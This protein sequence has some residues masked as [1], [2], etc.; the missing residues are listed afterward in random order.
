[1]TEYDLNQVDKPPSFLQRVNPV[2]PSNA[3]TQGMRAK[4][5]INCLVDEEGI[6]QNIIAA[7]CDPEDALDVFGPPSV[8]AVKK[9]RFNP[10]EIGGESVPTRIAFNIIFELDSPS[11]DVTP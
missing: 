9:W 5:K 8:E 10:G 6:A 4:V 2:Y 11:D 1:M 3:I 7:K